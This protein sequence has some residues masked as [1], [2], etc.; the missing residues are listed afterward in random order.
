MNKKTNSFWN[1]LAE[2]NVAF[3]VLSGGSF[4]GVFISDDSVA[5]NQA[6][7]VGE[8]SVSVYN[9]T[10]YTGGLITNVYITGFLGKDI[11]ADISANNSFTNGATANETIS[12][13]KD[14]VTPL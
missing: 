2:Y 9:S 7:I 8:R 6:T 1:D 13:V 3:S 12:I 14:T 5:Y 10:G 11:Y 4:T